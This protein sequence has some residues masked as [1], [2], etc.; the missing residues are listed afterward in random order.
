MA[1]SSDRA[2]L[3][4]GIYRF[5]IY[6]RS[7]SGGATTWPWPSVSYELTSPEFTVVPAEVNLEW[8]GAVLS[9]T[10]VAPPAGFRLIDIDGSSQGPNPVRGATITVIHDD[11][12]TTVT[13][14]E[15]GI[16]GGITTWTLDPADLDGAV[17]ISVEDEYGNAGLIEFD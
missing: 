11:S 12:E 17:A 16:S 9:G 1:H 14:V 15:E 6:G 2:G 13:P 10:M 4:T 5:H 7:Y 3:V 8:D